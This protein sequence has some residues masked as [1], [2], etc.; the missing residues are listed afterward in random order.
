MAVASENISHSEFLLLKV[1]HID[2]E[3]NSDN[4][5]AITDKMIYSHKVDLVLV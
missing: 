1:K 5:M 4:D 3:K 2:N